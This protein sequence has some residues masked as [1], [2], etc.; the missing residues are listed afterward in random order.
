MFGI[1]KNL[2][3]GVIAEIFPIF[4]EIFP[5]FAD[6]D[7]SPLMSMIYAL[8]PVVFMVAILKFIPQILRKFGG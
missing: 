2:V 1:I 7:M 4:A 6:V 3:L 8:I 5:I